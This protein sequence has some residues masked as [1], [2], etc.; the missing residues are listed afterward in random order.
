MIDLHSIGY[1][2]ED[3]I[4]DIQSSI[5]WLLKVGH[6]E[7]YTDIKYIYYTYYHELHLYEIHLFTF[8]YDSEEPE[9]IE[10]Q[11]ADSTDLLH[12][13]ELKTRFLIS[14]RNTLLT[15]PLT[16]SKEAF[17]KDLQPYFDGALSILSETISD[18]D[19]ASFKSGIQNLSNQK[20][21]PFSLPLYSLWL[22]HVVPEIHMIINALTNSLSNSYLYNEP[23][24]YIED[25]IFITLLETAPTRLANLSMDEARQLF[26]VDVLNEFRRRA[27]L[28]CKNGWPSE[29]NK[30]DVTRLVKAKEEFESRKRQNKTYALTYAR[31]RDAISILIDRATGTASSGQPIALKGDEA[32]LNRL[33]NL[34]IANLN[35]D[36]TSYD[37]FK[38][39][40]TG[41]C[42]AESPVHAEIQF[43]WEKGLSSLALFLYLLKKAEIPRNSKRFIG[44]IAQS[45][46][47]FYKRGTKYKLIT[48]EQQ[49]TDHARML[50]YL[51]NNQG[52]VNHLISLLTYWTSKCNDLRTCQEKI[53]QFNPDT[54][55]Q[56]L[57]P[58]GGSSHPTQSP[59]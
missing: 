11:H 34:I 31:Y 25:G 57:K 36:K 1:Q 29:N 49:L 54:L 18:F 21:I 52:E 10:H 53:K 22:D 46:C 7:G 51:E 45:N 5:R 23:E 9:I 3:F 14:Q 13:Q 33:Y 50:A 12:Q 55:S 6:P 43:F 58:T 24:I 37:A 47:F 27:N 44:A 40:F 48:R 26:S 15:S 59:H 19:P 39:L 30:K 8:H 28:Y 20:P 42:K 16:Y 35:T 56:A 2:L 41:N 38:T 4:P 17:G 32:S